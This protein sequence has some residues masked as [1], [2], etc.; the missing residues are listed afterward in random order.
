[1]DGFV[2]D[3]NAPEFIKPRKGHMTNDLDPVCSGLQWEDSFGTLKP[4][5]GSGQIVDFSDFKMGFLLGKHTLLRHLNTHLTM[6]KNLVHGPLI[7]SLRH[8]GTLNHQ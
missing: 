2:D 3:E 1:M 6:K 5:G 7:H 4:A 8:T